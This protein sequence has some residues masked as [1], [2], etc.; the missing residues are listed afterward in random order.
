[1]AL[2]PRIK[3]E[4]RHKIPDEQRCEVSYNGYHTWELVRKTLNSEPMLLCSKCLQHR[5]VF[6]D[7][8]EEETEKKKLDK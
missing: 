6:G 2:Y 5:M 4:D 8:I 1:M 3:D 7:V